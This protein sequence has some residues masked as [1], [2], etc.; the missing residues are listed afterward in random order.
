VSFEA[1]PARDEVPIGADQSCERT[2]FT[3]MSSCFYRPTGEVEDRKRIQKFA[4][5]IAD[6][7]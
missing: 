1:V 2:G 6:T 5:V 3:S 7:S 4:P